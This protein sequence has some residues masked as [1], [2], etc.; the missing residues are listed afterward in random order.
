MTLSDS[1]E[2]HGAFSLDPFMLDEWLVEPMLNRL[3]RNGE[4]T[5]LEPKV[6]DLLL[7]LAVRPGEALSRAELLERA[8]EDVIVG[9]EVLTRAVSELRRALHDNPKAPRYVDTIHKRGYCLI[10]PVS[11]APPHSRTL[12]R[13]TSRRPGRGGA[14]RW[15][16]SMY[17]SCQLHG[18]RRRSRFMRVHWR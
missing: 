10:A 5:H 16:R 11:P 13:E 2:N 7:C 18:S 9:D 3:S 6:M 8:W 4:S 1:T 15:R 14:G 12:E 17:R